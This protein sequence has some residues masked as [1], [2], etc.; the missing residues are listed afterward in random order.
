MV[1][2]FAPC[3]TQWLSFVAV[4]FPAHLSDSH[5][6][7]S[8]VWW[9][10]WEFFIVSLIHWL[11]PMMSLPGLANRLK[12][13]FREQ[14]PPCKPFYSSKKKNKKQKQKQKQTDPNDSADS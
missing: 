13:L 6:H 7:P 4:L 8:S 3:V 1:M 10:R 12:F 9:S 2:G 14:L 5:L 11:S